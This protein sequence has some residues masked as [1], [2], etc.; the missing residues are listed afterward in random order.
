MLAAVQ[1]LF[2]VA[3]QRRVASV[4][5]PS[6]AVATVGWREVWKI[7]LL[8][9]RLLLQSPSLEGEIC[10]GLL[11]QDNSCMWLFTGQMM[12]KPL[13]AAGKEPSS[14][15]PATA[16]PAQKLMCKGHQLVNTVHQ[17]AS[18]IVTGN[19]LRPTKLFAQCHPP[20]LSLLSRL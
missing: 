15:L 14:F 19:G 4:K 8:H 13:P 1:G 17:V 6:C 3:L 11:G 2:L 16:T 9:Q 5:P 20:H 7:K 10:P 18:A 12:T